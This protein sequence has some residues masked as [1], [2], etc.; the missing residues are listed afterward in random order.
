M[1]P[2][3][4]RAVLAA[5]LALF[6]VL[7]AAP[8]AR[9]DGVRTEA[10][11]GYLAAELAKAR[12]PGAAAQ[13]VTADGVLLDRTY[14]TLPA[15]RR[16]F[17]IGSLTKSLTA[18]AVLQ[19]VD[20]GRLELDAPAA[21][22]L[23]EL[24]GDD[25]TVRQLLTQ[26]S[27]YGTYDRP[28]ATT[29]SGRGS[30]RYANVNYT[31]A[32]RLV[33][34]ASGVEYGAYLRDHVFG[35]LGMRDSGTTDEAA[36]RATLVPGH[37]SWFGL[38]IAEDIPG[39]GRAD[40]WLSVPAGYA[41][42]TAPD[43][44]RYL[45][46]LLRGDA[47]VSPA[48][49]AELW[50]PSVAADGGHYAFGW[51]VRER[52]GVRVFVHSGLVENYATFMVVVP[53]RD[54][55]AVVLTNRNDFLVGNEGLEVLEKGLVDLL[56]GRQ[57]VGW[58]ASAHVRGHVLLDAALLLL[59]AVAATSFWRVYRPPRRPRLA[60]VVG[61]VLHLALPVGLLA[62]PPLLGTEMA[63]VHAFVPDVYWVLILSVTMLFGGGLGK[64]VAAW[65]RRRSASG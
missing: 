22:W 27:G 37:R 26:T 5:C 32:G 44:G 46:A 16:G 39:P 4:L 47:G 64:L 3:S 9:A 57:P 61:L 30:F 54:V 36:V 35:P 20:A 33:G 6:L 59:F 24:G 31:L 56:V 53:E 52:E 48:G 12:V 21:R 10:V 17:V 7:A 1:V 34:A 63:A 18:L 11:D 28:G 49:M 15:D 60:L 65:G 41:I 38:D 19:L 58:D 42:S 55:A 25:V 14:G 43:M 13:V 62:L 2:R 50:R 40:G 51:F 8:T 23:P 45:G 29:V